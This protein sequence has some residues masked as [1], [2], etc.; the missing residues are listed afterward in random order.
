MKI[1]VVFMFVS[2]LMFWPADRVWSQSETS[3]NLEPCK[4][5]EELLQLDL[6]DV[7]ITEATFRG[8]TKKRCR[9]KGVIGEE[10]N[11]TLLLPFSWNE[12]F[13]MGGGG[14]FV[15]VVQNQQWARVNQGYATVGTDTGHEGPLLEAGWALNNIERQANFGFLAVHRT[16]ETAKAIISDYYG[17]KPIYSYF[18]GCS[19]GGGQALVEAQRYP[20]DFDGIL[21]GAPAFDW[22]GIGLE[23]IDNYR[24]MYSKESSQKNLPTIKTMSLLNKI[25]LEKYDHLD[26]V[27]D[28]II[29]N[30]SDFSFDYSSLPI[31]P[32]DKT[33]SDCFTLTQIEKIKLLYEGVT[34]N[35]K[36]ISPGFPIG[37]EIVLYPYHIAIDSSV[38][39]LGQNTVFGAFGSEIYKYLVFNDPE[40]DLYNYDY[41][42]FWNDTKY[43]A[44]VLNATSTDYDRFKGNGGKM[45]IYHGWN[46]QS[47][48][49]LRTIE[50]YN[51]IKNA[52]SEVDD[53]IKMYLPPGMEHCIGGIGPSEV[54][55]L[56]YLRD[57]VENGKEP[58]KI[59]LSKYENDSLVMTRPVFPYPSVA[60]YNGQGDPND[61]NNFIELKK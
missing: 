4:E 40:W 41:N 39:H 1:L 55:W 15:G 52:D 18:G 50:Y 9:I 33:G 61:H 51:E 44:S 14:A 12:R 35:G 58:H 3:E 27:K 56:V 26:G 19:R 29:N 22:T 43:A 20:D 24:N 32:E 37:T 49:A 11:F 7:V 2:L 30:P 21:C 53:Y 17:T 59:I 31:C 54:D 8:S 5:C 46:D 48:T 57:W 47:I 25:I 28:G 34:V 10:I 36:E 6:P 38:L 23:C 13:V 42:N 60:G 16:A 45:I